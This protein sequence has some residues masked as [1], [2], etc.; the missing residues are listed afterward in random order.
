MLRGH[1]HWFS[2]PEAVR[3][4]VFLS[5]ALG[6]IAVKRKCMNSRMSLLFGL[7]SL[8]EAKS[9]PDYLQYGFTDED[10]PD[11]LSLVAAYAMGEEASGRGGGGVSVHAWRVLGQLGSSEAI[12]PLVELFGLLCD[13]DLALMEIPVVMGMLGEPAIGPLEACF[14]DTGLGEYA[15]C[16][17]SEGLKEIALLYPDQ[18]EAVVTVLTDYLR[19]PDAAALV[20]N[21]SGVAILMDL[22]AT[23]SMDVVRS[24]YERGLAEIGFCGDIEDVEIG[25]GLRKNRSTPRPGYWETKQVSDYG[26]DA[27]DDGDVIEY[28]LGRYGH[29]DSVRDI[30]ELDGFLTAIGCAPELIKPSRWLPAIWGGEKGAP[31]WQSVEEAQTFTTAV[32]VAYNE[33]ITDLSQSPYKAMFNQRVV[34]GVTHPVV[35]E[36]CKGFLRGY[37]LWQPL[38]ALDLMAMDEQLQPMRLFAT[39]EGDEHRDGLSE[40]DIT[41]WKQRIE[42]TVGRIYKMFSEQRQSVSQPVQRVAPKVGRNDPCPCGSGK[43]Y[44]KCCLQ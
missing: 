26:S 30:S 38:T 20:V 32:T 14:R 7:D 31:A 10:V 40:A 39:E 15:R 22:K 16:M 25:F 6:G 44:K 12:A 42:P 21:A 9:W 43:K 18:R 5:P 24:L 28:F 33:A 8:D 1:H 27:D 34:E 19:D 4:L 2:L 41:Q 11:L 36:W 37:A 13:D 3:L 35:D 17:A 29:G 23:E